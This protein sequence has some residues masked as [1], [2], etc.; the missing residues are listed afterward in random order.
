MPNKTIYVAEDDLPLF[1]Q[2]LE[3][4]DN[5]SATIA[6]ALRMYVK[7]EKAR[8]EGF[9]KITVRVGRHGNRHFKR[10]R[11]Y[12]LTRWANTTTDP[13]RVVIFSVY[14]TQGGRF[15]IHCR[16]SPNWAV[17]TDPENWTE[18]YSSWR[19]DWW[20]SG[21]ATLE[22]YDSLEEVREHVPPELFALVEE[23]SHE[24]PLEELDI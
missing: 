20:Q 19:Y 8:R 11:G 15:A 24:P 3:F 6:K 12:R 4:G 22:V 9:E 1:E 13:K 14:K 18:E 10:F 16:K 17:W 21:E 5:L 7:E 23:A 2:A